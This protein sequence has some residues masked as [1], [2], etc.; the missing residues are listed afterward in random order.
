[1]AI[2]GRGAGSEDGRI[3][4]F[5]A[6]GWLVSSLQG[7][8]VAAGRRFAP[9]TPRVAWDRHPAPQSCCH[10]AGSATVPSDP[11]PFDRSPVAA[12]LRCG[13]HWNFS[14]LSRRTEVRSVRSAA[15]ALSSG[16]VCAEGKRHRGSSQANP[17][18]GGIVAIP[19]TAAIAGATGRATQR[20]FGRGARLMARYQGDGV[21]LRRGSLKPPSLALAGNQGSGA[22]LAPTIRECIEER[23][24]RRG[25]PHGATRLAPPSVVAGQALAAADAGIRQVRGP[26]QDLPGR[27]GA[28]V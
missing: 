5:R 27:G 20:P 23:Q 12:L 18:A 22:A 16:A 15:S 21:G 10:R 14:A 8:L 7:G 25:H 9:E 19:R 11:R 1:M 13:G 17:Y 26:V 6:D 3:A 4:S 24:D 28:G 2:L